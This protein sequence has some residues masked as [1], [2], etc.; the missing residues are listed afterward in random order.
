MHAIERWQL[1][2]AF[3]SSKPDTCRGGPPWP[4]LFGCRYIVYGKEG[5]PR[6]AAP[7]CVSE[8]LRNYFAA[9]PLDE[10]NRII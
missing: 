9:S 7:T 4:P 8:S 10:V 5:R 6:R 2:S 1:V 3:T